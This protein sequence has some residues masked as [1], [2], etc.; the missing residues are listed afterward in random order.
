MTFKCPFCPRYFS[1]RSAYT[2]HKNRCIPSTNNNNDSEEL[3][4]FEL[5]SNDHDI[6]VRNRNY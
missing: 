3:E 4:E 6:E 2:Q 5:K 1:S